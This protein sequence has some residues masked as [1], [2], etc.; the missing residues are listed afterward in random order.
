MQIN[1]DRKI[2]I[3]LRLNDIFVKGITDIIFRLQQLH[4]LL[5]EST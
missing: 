4:L 5:H 2:C 3:N 1:T